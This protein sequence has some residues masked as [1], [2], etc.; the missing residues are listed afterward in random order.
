MTNYL[1][2]AQLPDGTIVLRRSDD[3]DNPIVKIEF[4]K[5]SKDFL[6]G[7]ITNDINKCDK[8]AIYSCL[9]SPQGKFLSDFFVIPFKDSFLIE[10]NQEF[11]DNFISRLKIY[12]LRSKIEIERMNFL[13]SIIVLK[14]STD[15]S[16]DVGLIISLFLSFCPT[17]NP[18]E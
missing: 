4:S 11:I 16:L 15:E 18:F 7:I 13:T 1:E 10:I 3:H 17:V 12:K 8:R 2:L 5:D 14:E 6:Q 9:L